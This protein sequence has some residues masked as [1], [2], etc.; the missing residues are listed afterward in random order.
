MLKQV[1]LEMI[2]WLSRY[3]GYIYKDMTLISGYQH[4]DI[5]RNRNFCVI[6]LFSTPIHTGSKIRSLCA[7]RYLILLLYVEN[8]IPSHLKYPYHFRTS[9]S[10]LKASTRRSLQIRRTQEN[11]L[12]TIEATR[13]KETATTHIVQS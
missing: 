13:S 5:L 8:V 3:A 10:I 11:L 6:G 2:K 12:N 7:S 9:K 1:Y 4:G